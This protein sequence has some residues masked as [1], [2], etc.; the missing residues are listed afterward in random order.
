MANIDRFM[1]QGRPQDTSSVYKARNIIPA[2]DALGGVRQMRCRAPFSGTLGWNQT[3]ALANAGVK[4]C[5]TLPIKDINV[6][7]ND[8]VAFEALKPGCVLAIELPNEPDLNPVTYNGVTDQRLGARTGNAPALMA[9]CNDVVALIKTKPTLANVP[10]VAFNDW[11]HTEQAGLADFGNSHIYPKPTTPQ[12]NWISGWNTKLTNLGKPQGF[13]TEWGRTTG[14]NSSN[15]VSPPV[16]LQQQADLLV[17]DLT[18]IF[19]QPSV[20]VVSIY[21]LFAWSGSGEQDN[22]GL[23]NYDLS[24]RPAVSAIRSLLI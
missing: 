6:L 15:V 22:F 18:T 14:G 8:I 7:V 12:G 5:F 24:P 13:I 11:M 1:V 3:V 21:E 2:L 4:F 16:T 20:A 9:F 19:A 17:Q 10:I 23:F